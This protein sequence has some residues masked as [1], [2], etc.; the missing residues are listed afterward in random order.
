MDDTPFCRDAGFKHANVQSKGVFSYA[1]TV[2]DKICGWEDEEKWVRR[3]CG[4]APKGVDKW[5]KNHTRNAG[6]LEATFVVHYCSRQ[7]DYIINPKK[8]KNVNVIAMQCT[9]ESWP[10]GFC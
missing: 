9:G 4:S 10:C 2:M 1:M 7:K 6:V 5:A 3:S 8:A